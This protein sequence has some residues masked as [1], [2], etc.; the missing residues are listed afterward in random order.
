M[1]G[2]K[3]LFSAIAMRTSGRLLCKQKSLHDL[4][5]FPEILQIVMADAVNDLPVDLTEVVYGDIADS[6]RLFHAQFQFTV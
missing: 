5:E 2:A 3:D 1:T 6:N 4:C